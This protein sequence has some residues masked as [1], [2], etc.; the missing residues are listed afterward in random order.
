MDPREGN[1][2]IAGGQSYGQDLGFQGIGDV[3]PMNAMY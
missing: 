1:N 2:F 3:D